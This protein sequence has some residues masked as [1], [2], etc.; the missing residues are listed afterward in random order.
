MT[1]FD[2]SLTDKLLRQ[3]MVPLADYP[4][5]GKLTSDIKNQIFDIHFNII[6]PYT[7]RPLSLRVS[8]LKCVRIS[9]FLQYIN[10]SLPTSSILIYSR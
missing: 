6:F 9:C 4:K 10:M 1:L 8:D 2:L 5:A 7:S 3:F